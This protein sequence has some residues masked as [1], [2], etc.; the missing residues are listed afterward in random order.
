M[1][2]RDAQEYAYALTMMICALLFCAHARL[3]IHP[4]RLL[5]QPL[6]LLFAICPSLPPCCYFA[7]FVYSNAALIGCP[8]YAISF[9]LCGAMFSRHICLFYLRVMPTRLIRVLADAHS[10][11]VARRHTALL[12]AAAIIVYRHGRFSLPLSAR[13]LIYLAPRLPPI[14]ASHISPPICYAR[15]P[16][17]TADACLALQYCCHATLACYMPVVRR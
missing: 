16:I 12:V 17:A 10:R 1:P 4:R 14:S 8:A 15:P 5:M 11:F 2:I 3:P 6:S 7:V 13:V 9:I